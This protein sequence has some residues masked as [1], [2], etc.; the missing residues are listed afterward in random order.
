MKPPGIVSK[1]VPG[2]FLLTNRFRDEYNKIARLPLK[3][4]EIKCI[5]NVMNIFK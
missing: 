5:K 4:M 1:S 2:G 3:I